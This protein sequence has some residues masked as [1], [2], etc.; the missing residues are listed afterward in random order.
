MGVPTATCRSKLR[1]S[2]ST[3]N[4]FDLLFTP[5]PQL[6][7]QFWIERLLIRKRAPC[8]HS[9]ILG[10]FNLSVDPIGTVRLQILPTFPLSSPAAGA[11]PAYKGVIAPY[12]MGY[13][14]IRARIWVIEPAVRARSV[15]MFPGCK[16]IDTMPSPPYRRASSF[17]IRIFP[18]NRAYQKGW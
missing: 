7:L 13:S 6:L 15:L 8:P 11:V 12:V 17:E 10:S 18:C 4:V 5:L 16:E 3:L 2:D 1:T 9:Q 14:I